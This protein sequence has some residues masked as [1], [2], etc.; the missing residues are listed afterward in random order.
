MVSCIN[1]QGSVPEKQTF[2][3]VFD[4]SILEYYSTRYEKV[5]ILDDFNMEAENKVNKDFLQDHTFYNKMKQNT[6]F[7][8]DGGSCIDLLIANSKFSFMKTNPF[9]T[10]LSDHHHMIYTILKTKFVKFEPKKSTYR[11]LKQC[12]SGQFKWIFSILFLL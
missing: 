5:I 6:C 10:G 7:K 3:L 4:K 1:L 9:E 12:D 8:G 2:S 11:N